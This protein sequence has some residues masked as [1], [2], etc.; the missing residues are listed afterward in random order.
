MLPVEVTPRLHSHF[1]LA[2]LHRNGGRNQIGMLAG[3]APEQCPVSRR[4]GGRN[5]PEY[6]AVTFVIFWLPGINII[7]HIVAGAVGN[8]LYYKHA[9]DKIVEIRALQPPQNLYP[10]LQQVGGV[11][12]W[13]I[14]VGVVAGI[15]IAVLMFMVI[16]AIIGLSR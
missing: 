1:A 12:G 8:Y 4:N 14:P 2:G 13:V 7:L 6:A 5:D 15:F 9:K 3:F 16:A 10:V 11:H